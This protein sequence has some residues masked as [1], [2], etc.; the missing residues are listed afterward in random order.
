MGLERYLWKGQRSNPSKIPN[1]IRITIVFLV[2]LQ[3]NV[4]GNVF[5][6][7]KHPKKHYYL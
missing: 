6:G 4:L 3:S 2:V 1:L 5:W 7:A